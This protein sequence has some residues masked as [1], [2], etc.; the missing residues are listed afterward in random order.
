MAGKAGKTIYLTECQAVA[1]C[2]DGG[3]AVTFES[4]LGDYL[5][6]HYICSPESFEV[7]DYAESKEQCRDKEQEGF[8]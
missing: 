1:L 7:R 6:K 5:K 2:A 4:C 3:R 8:V